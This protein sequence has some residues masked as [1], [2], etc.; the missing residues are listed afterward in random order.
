MADAASQIS[1]R[2]G[3]SD[4]FASATVGGVNQALGASGVAAPNTGET[5]PGTQPGSQ[6]GAQPPAGSTDGATIPTTEGY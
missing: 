4:A 2:Y 3:D 1:Q 5:Q 6:P